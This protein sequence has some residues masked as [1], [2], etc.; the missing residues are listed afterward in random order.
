MKKWIQAIAKKCGLRVSR[1]TPD[2]FEEMQALL[3][4]VEEPIIFDVGAHHGGVSKVFRQR[5]PSATI[6]AFEPFKASFH[7][8]KKNT[9]SD[10]KT[11]IFN[12]GLS[13]QSGTFSF[14]ANTSSATNSLLSTDESSKRVW[15]PGLMETQQTVEAEFRTLDSVVEE[16]EIPRIDLLKLDVQGAEHLVLAGASRMFA[17]QAIRL[18]Y[19]EIILQPSYRGQKRFDEA[20]ADYYNNGFDLYRI[21]HLVTSL[22][23]RHCQMDVIFTRNQK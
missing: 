21:F 15:R 18:I 1:W 13:D 3:A 23:G 17:R 7:E 19:S 4:G 22:E 2:A 9:A 14:H 6:Y 16:L 12:Y 20:L 10:A 5:F 8:L 11:R